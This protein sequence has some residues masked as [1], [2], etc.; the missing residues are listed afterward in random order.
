VVGF[1]G[2]PRVAKVMLYLVLLTFLIRFL[3]LVFVLATTREIFHH[4]DPFVA[5]LALEFPVILQH[6]PITDNCENLGPLS[7]LSNSNGFYVFVRRRTF[8]LKAPQ[9]SSSSS[10]PRFAG[11]PENETPGHP[12]RF[13]H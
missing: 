1:T 4:H 12:L 6:Q 13:P 5:F 7:A 9:S 8:S 11:R 10:T 2:Q 3:V